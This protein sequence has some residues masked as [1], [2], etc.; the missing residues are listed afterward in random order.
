MGLCG[1]LMIL[2]NGASI[3]VGT[4]DEVAGDRQVQEIYLGADYA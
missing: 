2:N 3:I 4:P 1:R